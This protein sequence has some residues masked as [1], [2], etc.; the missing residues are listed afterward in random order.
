MNKETNKE[1]VLDHINYS[2]Y[3]KEL[4]NESHNGIDYRGS[5]LAG[6]TIVIIIL[7]IPILLILESHFDTIPIILILGFFLNLFVFLF[8][9]IPEILVFAK[10]TF[11][12]KSSVFIREFLIAFQL[13]LF[14]CCWLL[15]ILPL[16]KEYSI[17]KIPLMVGIILLMFFILL[18]DNS[19][20]RKP[21]LI[22]KVKM[23]ISQVPIVSVHSIEVKEELNGYSQ[24]PISSE[25]RLLENLISSSSSFAENIEDFCV[26]LGK[27]GELIDWC[28]EDSFAILYPRFI[29]QRPNIFKNPLFYYQLLKKIRLNEDMT[30]IEITLSPPQIS[31]NIVFQDYETLNRETTFHTLCLHIL[32]SVKKSLIAFLNNDP[33]TAYHELT[34]GREIEKPFIQDIVVFNLF[35]SSR[36][37]LA[38]IYTTIL[39]RKKKEI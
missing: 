30:S 20:K 24:R 12:T 15:Y 3:P 11:R 5:I 1:T 29:V 27:K 28:I 16:S 34:R 21:L 18:Q 26:F 35:S 17:I 38:K 33:D 7:T 19:Y 8:I 10:I 14:L 6:I 32:E 25:F 36:A 4:K 9:A 2:D 31:I 39:K 37:F 13:P 23:G 22:Q